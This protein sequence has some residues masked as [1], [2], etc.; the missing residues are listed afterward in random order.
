MH[1]K[2]HPSVTGSAAR[3]LLRVGMVVR[4]PLSS[5]RKSANLLHPTNVASNRESGFTYI[6]SRDFENLSYEL[7]NYPKFTSL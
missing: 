1:K 6:A 5:L 7:A 2:H 3:N 4:M